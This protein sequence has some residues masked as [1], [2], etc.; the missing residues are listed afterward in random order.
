MLREYED[1]EIRNSK[2]IYC[3]HKTAVGIGDTSSYGIQPGI[4]YYKSR[5]NQFC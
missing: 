3:M 5:S 4:R 1:S 2:L